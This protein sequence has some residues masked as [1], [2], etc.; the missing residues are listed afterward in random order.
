[1]RP[2]QETIEKRI[3]EK[4]RPEEHIKEYGSKGL[5]IKSEKYSKEPLE[6]IKFNCRFYNEEKTA[7]SGNS[8]IIIDSVLTCAGA[9]N[10]DSDSDGVWTTVYTSAGAS[11]VIDQWAGYY[12]KTSGLYFYIKSNTATALTIRAVPGIEPID[13]DFEIVPFIAHSMYGAEL[14]PDTTQETVFQIVNN[15]DTTI[16]VAPNNDSFLTDVAVATDPFTVK[17]YYAPCLADFTDTDEGQDAGVIQ[18]KIVNA[19]FGKL[20]DK[21]MGQ[22]FIGVYSVRLMTFRSKT[23]RLKLDV[24]D[25]LRIVEYE[26]DREAVLVNSRFGQNKVQFISLYF[27]ANVWKR[28]DIFYY[29]KDGDY[30]FTITGADKPIGDYIDAWSDVT[31]EVPQWVSG[32]PEGQLRQIEL[33]WIN[34]GLLGQG[35]GTQIF[36]SDDDGATYS[37]KAFVPWDHNTYFD[38]S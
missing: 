15:T 16:T 30:G 4:Q 11:W 5:F 36:R 17:G 22:Y 3:D 34:T 25:S 28:L 29:T 31:P 26:S 24:P 18:S 21:N 23:V 37:F 10:Y 6:D 8:T 27:M 35:G 19:P 2:Q 7:Y 32:Y 38:S 12:L 9:S 20:N 14:N 33:R 1:M 13:G